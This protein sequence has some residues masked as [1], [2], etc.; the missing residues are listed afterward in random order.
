MQDDIS[1]LRIKG[2]SVTLKTCTHH[3]MFNRNSKQWVSGTHEPTCK[4]V[5]VCISQE[6][7]TLT[8]FFVLLMGVFVDF[9]V[10]AFKKSQY[11]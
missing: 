7:K 6:H 9:F 2:P 1:N 11:I 3:T 8:P 10:F 5:C 4:A